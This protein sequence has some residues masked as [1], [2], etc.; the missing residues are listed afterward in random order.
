MRSV[1]TNFE[2]SSFAWDMNEVS[3]CAN[4]VVRWGDWWFGGH[5]LEVHRQCEHSIERIRRRIHF[6]RN[7]IRL[8]CTVFSRSREFFVENRKFFLHH[9]HPTLKFGVNNGGGDG[10]GSWGIA[11]RPENASEAVWVTMLCSTSAWYGRMIA[12]S[13]RV[14]EILKLP[15]LG[16]LSLNRTYYALK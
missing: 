3:K 12:C 15:S 2:D 16:G 14:A 6:H 4:G 8:S 10:T 9:V 7:Y 13:C 11:V 5:S 1:S